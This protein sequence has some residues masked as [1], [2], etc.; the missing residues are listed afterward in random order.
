MEIEGNLRNCMFNIQDE[1]SFFGGES[2]CVCGGGGGQRSTWLFCADF[3][4]L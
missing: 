3:Y 2:V 4:A 1:G